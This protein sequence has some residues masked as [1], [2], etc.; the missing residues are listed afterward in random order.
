MFC[1]L[2]WAVFSAQMLNR[3]TDLSETAKLPVEQVSSLIASMLLKPVILVHC[4]CI[5]LLLLSLCIIVVSAV[6]R[7][8]WIIEVSNNI[9]SNVKFF[10]PLMYVKVTIQFC[11]HWDK[12]SVFSDNCCRRYSFPSS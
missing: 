12:Y 4:I 3:G 8:L 6:R 7:R 5:P 1:S 9:I 2:R 11:Y 10:C